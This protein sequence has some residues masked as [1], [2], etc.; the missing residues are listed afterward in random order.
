[1][2]TNDVEEPGEYELG[3]YKVTVNKKEEK[4]PKLKLC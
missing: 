2:I 4:R 1:M 3:I